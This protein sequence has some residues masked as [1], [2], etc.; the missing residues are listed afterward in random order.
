MA[1]AILKNVNAKRF[2]Q[3]SNTPTA[4]ESYEEPE[5]SY[6]EVLRDKVSRM[7]R[8]RKRSNSN[9]NYRGASN[10]RSNVTNFP[11]NTATNYT[12][13][14]AINVNTIIGGL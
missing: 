4:A 1:K 2:N 9:N 14:A 7:S 13:R 11:Q 12:G 8:Q 3:S 5:F 6:N 10:L